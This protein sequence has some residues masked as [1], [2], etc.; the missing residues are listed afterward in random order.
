VEFESLT[1]QT[2]KDLTIPI[3]G[4]SDLYQSLETYTQVE[5]L[6]GENQYFAPGHGYQDAKKV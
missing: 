5:E 2:F 3:Q 4:F 6:K 1:K